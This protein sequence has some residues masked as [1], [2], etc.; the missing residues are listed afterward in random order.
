VLSKRID[1]AGRQIAALEQ[2]E[3]ATLLGERPLEVPG[4][5]VRRGESVDVVCMGIACLA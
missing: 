5:G 3:R 2:R 1:D 4:L